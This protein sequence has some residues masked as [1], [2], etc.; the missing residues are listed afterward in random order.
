MS[1]IQIQQKNPA[2]PQCR[3]TYTVKKGKRRN[4]LQTVPLYLC[5]ECTHRFSGTPGK[6]K[7]YP[8]KIILEAI[9]AYNL[10]HSLT[11]TQRILR[12]R[13]HLDVPE[14]TIRSWLGDHRPLITY[15]RLRTAGKKLFDATSIL[16][17]FTFHHQQVYR[18]QIHQAK[19][20]L[21]LPTPAHQHLRPVKQYLGSVGKSLDRKSVV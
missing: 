1:S 11:D 8:L 7:T 16:R 13:A 6:H 4:R 21:L 15:S 20:E 14:R 10:G 3:S 17:S 19:L 12:Q 2:C 18:F 5:N 9:S